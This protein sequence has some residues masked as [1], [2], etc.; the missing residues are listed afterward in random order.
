M[1]FDVSV[2]KCLGCLLL[3]EECINIHISLITYIWADIRKTRYEK[4][5]SV[6]NVI[7]LIGVLSKR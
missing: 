5:V 6:I 2:F 7:S 4:V 1:C 3:V